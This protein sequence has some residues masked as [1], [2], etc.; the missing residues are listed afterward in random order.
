MDL[1]L[2]FYFFLTLMSFES[3]IQADKVTLSTEL[4]TFELKGP[5]FSS[6]GYIENILFDYR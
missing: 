2:G 6:A 4:L 3:N 5:F 1:L